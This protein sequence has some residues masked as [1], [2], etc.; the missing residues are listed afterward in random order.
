M[1]RRS[2]A[3]GPQCPGLITRGKRFV[4]AD[5][6]SE[7]IPCIHYGEINMMLWISACVC[8]L[9]SGRWR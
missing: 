9:V 6:T 8:S 2:P 4:K 5:M 7:D 3:Q 1:S